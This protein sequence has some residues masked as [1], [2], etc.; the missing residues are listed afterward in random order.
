MT[1]ITITGVKVRRAMVPLRR[2]LATSFGV[3]T[4]G[5][6]LFIDLECAGGIVG[7]VNGFTFNALAQRLVPEVLSELANQFKGRTISLADVPAVHDAGQKKLML[8]GHEGI[9]QL[10]LSMFDMALHDALGRACGQPLYRMLEGKRREIQAYN[11]CGMGIA[12]PLAL[13]R[14]ARELCSE[15]GGYRHI[16]M[17]L[18]RA[19]IADDLTAIRAV[20]EALG[21]A[22]Q[23]SVD[24]NQALSSSAALE[25]C[26]LID[27]EGLDWIEEP[28]VYDDY[29]TQARLTAKLSTPVQIGETW[30]HWR[31][32]QRA[33]AMRA[34]DYCMPDILR[35]GGVTGWMRTARAAEGASMPMSSHLSPEYSVHVLAASP[36]CHWL[37]Y[38]DWSQDLLVDPLVPHKGMVQPRDT[39]GVGIDWNE[40][41]LAKVLV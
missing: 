8:S 40:A 20:R 1:S 37:E 33:I 29:E 38:M 36:T 26:R 18:G 32:A 24:F 28:V 27:R 12:E 13:V 23:V 9:T 14:E 21:S 5:P 15:N 10:G 17:R 34:S 19:D 16:K 41:A 7:R 25:A 2:A 31:V 39:P 4:H 6:F 22:V 35:I 3:F 11:S 30:W